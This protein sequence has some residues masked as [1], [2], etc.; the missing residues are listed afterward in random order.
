MRNTVGVQELIDGELVL[1]K[2]PLRVRHVRTNGVAGRTVFI[3]WL[4]VMPIIEVEQKAVGEDL[5]HRYE[6]APAGPHLPGRRLFQ[7]LG[8]GRADGRSLRE[9]RGCKH[10]GG[11]LLLG[12]ACTRSH[13]GEDEGTGEKCPKELAC[14]LG[15]AHPHWWPNQPSW[16]GPAST[17]G[18]AHVC[19]EPPPFSS[20]GLFI[21]SVIGHHSYWESWLFQ[22][23]THYSRRFSIFLAVSP[24]KISYPLD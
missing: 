11:G 3:F 6:I 17:T 24:H 21:S 12:K 13:E 5:K 22:S 7:P 20:H 18:Y 10:V 16:T 23:R 14:M 19:A 9:C 4:G 2:D 1:V 8:I 15:S